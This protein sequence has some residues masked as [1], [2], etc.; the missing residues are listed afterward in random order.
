MFGWMEESKKRE[1]PTYTILFKAGD[2]RGAMSV[3][4]DSYG[5]YGSFI[6]FYQRGDNYTVINLLSVKTEDVRMIRR[7]KA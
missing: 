7:T 1:L 6:T 5:E 4:A 3:D 2:S